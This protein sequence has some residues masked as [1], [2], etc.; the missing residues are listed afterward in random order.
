MKRI[1]GKEIGNANTIEDAIKFLSNEGVVKI[2][3]GTSLKKPQFLFGSRFIKLV[4]T[5]KGEKT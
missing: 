5:G 2:R 4:H 3:E 1:H